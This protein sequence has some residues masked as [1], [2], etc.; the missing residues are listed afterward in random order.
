MTKCTDRQEKGQQPTIVEPLS[1]MRPEDTVKPY[2]SE[3][4]NAIRAQ[5]LKSGCNQSQRY[6]MLENTNLTELEY[7]R[8]RYERFWKRPIDLVAAIIG[9]LVTSPLMLAVALAIRYVMGKP[10][11]FRQQRPGQDERIFTLIKFRTMVEPTHDSTGH[12]LPDSDRLTKLG[13]F[14]RQSSL[15]ELPQMVNVA[16]GHMSFV[17]PRPLAVQYLKSYSAVEKL[18][19][20]V[21]PGITG[22][23]QINGRNKLAWEQRFAYDVQYVQNLTVRRDFDIIL[24]TFTAVFRRSDIAIHGT[25]TVQDFDVYRLEQMQH[26]E[27][28][29]A[30]LSSSEPVA[31]D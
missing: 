24:R 20:E 25:D 4:S 7:S 5:A 6:T 2:S 16:L 13:A 30:G 18:R 26:A 21:R 22:L 29:N 17:G 9:L 14:L 27:E 3:T 1:A 31:E 12:V 28:R 23:A 11:L 8:T 19:H 10:I 15:D